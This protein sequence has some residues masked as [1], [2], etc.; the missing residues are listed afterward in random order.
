MNKIIETKFNKE[1]YVEVLK[2]RYKVKLIELNKKTTYV[3]SLKKDIDLLE[4]TNDVEILDIKKQLNSL[5]ILLDKEL[6]LYDTIN[7]AF[8]KVE[9]EIK[10]YES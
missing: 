6:I 10:K 5:K 4:N 2:C 1:L 9:G 7:K 3:N 8:I